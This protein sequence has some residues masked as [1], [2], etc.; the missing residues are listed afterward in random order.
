MQKLIALPSGENVPNL[1]LGTWR[2]GEHSDSRAQEINAL[3]AG[4]ALGMNLI[5]TAEMYGEGGAEEVIAEA[6]T[7][8]RD[9]VFLVSK[10]YPHNASR[11]GAVKACE[12]SLK[13]LRTDRIDLYLLHWRGQFPLDETL[14][15]FQHL[16]ASGKIRHFGVSNFDTD[17]MSEW[18]ALDGTAST[19]SNQVIYNLNRRGIEWDL[20]PWCLEKGIPLMAYSPLDQGALGHQVALKKI[21]QKHEVAPAQIALAWVVRQ[22]NVIAIPKAT[23]LQHVEQNRAAL[24]IELDAE[25]LTEL[26]RA[27]PPPGSAQPLDIL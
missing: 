16:I 27:F 7:D 11:T 4:L 6:I 2:M 19:A 20:L 21:A 10:V 12:R 26:E 3:R 9:E 15:A 25:D 18:C 13:R 14:E 1:G 24:D 23:D 5:D 17:D 22:D 8:R